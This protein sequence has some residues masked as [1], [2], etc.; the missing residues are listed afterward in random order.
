MENNPQKQILNDFSMIQPI[1]FI[2]G[3]PGPA[4]WNALL[5]TQHFYP[6]LEGAQTADVLIIG[7]GFAG[8]TAARRLAVQAPELNVVVLEARH[9]A[10]GPAGRNSGFMVDLPHDLSSEDY[11]GQA[12]ADKLQIRQNRLAIQFARETAEEFGYVGE[13]FAPSGKFNAAATQKGAQHNGEY[14][15]HL[16]SIGET[17][18]RLDAK[19][20]R[21]MTGTDFFIDG[22]YT[23]GAAM[24]QP[25][26]Y[27]R[28]LGRA[29]AT[30]ATIY[31]NS[32][33][34][35]LQR[36]GDGWLAKTS[37]GSVTAPK[38]ILAVN[39]MAEKFGYFT[40]RLMHIFTYASMTRALSESEVKRLGG[41]PKWGATPADP[42][43]T[44]V[45]RIN[46]LNGDRLLVRNTFRLDQSMASPQ[47]KLGRVYGA[48]DRSYTRRFPMLAGVEMQYRWGGRLCLSW[49]NVHG[50]SELEPGLIAACCQLGIGVTK[51]SLLG[52]AAADMIAGK[53]SPALEPLKAQQTDLR[54]LPPKPLA[55][56]GAN[57]YM[58]WKEHRADAEL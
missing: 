51:G 42:M 23:P 40:G 11:A 41:Q 53:L 50:L 37:R 10:E 16:A 21:E 49:N 25:A 54:R 48:H 7:A 45:R 18:E 30:Q 20:M 34:T 56:L 58:R 43:G 38:V 52:L 33:V 27:I 8:L 36:L 24:V 22:L 28:E 1:Q 9:L 26:L 4:A 35:H 32:A 5:P 47:E 3:D 19:A 57:A 39:G 12:E 29:V 14:A 15:K 46:G 44:T 2:A 55:N 17:S 6:E 31:E 13:A